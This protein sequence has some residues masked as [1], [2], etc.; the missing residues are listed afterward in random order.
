MDK[1]LLFDGL[2]VIFM[3]VLLYRAVRWVIGRRASPL[4]QVRHQAVGA[5]CEKY[6]LAP[7]QINLPPIFRITSAME[8]TA[9]ENS[10]VSADGAVSAADCWRN[11]D[12]TWRAFSLLVFAVPGLNM[13]GVAVTRRDLP[14]MPLVWGS[15]QVGLESIEFNARFVVRAQNRHSAVMLLDEGMMQW[16]MD[17]EQ[18]SFE[19]AADWVVALVTRRG[20]PTNQPSLPSA[21]NPRRTDPV[22][23]ELLFKF[24]QGFVPRV[25]A[26]LRTEFPVGSLALGD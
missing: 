4:R 20:E 15:Q 24:W 2:W 14:G 21:S 18:V 19:I 7:G 8:P 1:T 9:F 23:L 6:G 25:P 22:E 11:T 12:K 10:F 17:C 26:I 13:P 3:L 16:L 5:L